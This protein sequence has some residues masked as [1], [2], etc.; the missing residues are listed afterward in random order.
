M[1]FKQDKLS[2]RGF[3][4]AV[5]KNRIYYI[6]N[7]KSE[8]GVYSMNMNGSDIQLEAKNPSITHIQLYKDN[9]YYL[10]LWEIDK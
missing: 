6:S 1:N 8:P 10:G 3:A 2:S 4:A 7:E 5:Y 9:L